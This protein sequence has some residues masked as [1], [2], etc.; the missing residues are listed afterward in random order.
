MHQTKPMVHS[1]LILFELHGI[2]SLAALV[3]LFP[4]MFV[5][6]HMQHLLNHTCSIREI[7]PSSGSGPCP[8]CRKPLRRTDLIDTISEV[9]FR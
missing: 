6:S 1:G 5:E 9:H 2:V 4:L 8:I 7:V 3:I